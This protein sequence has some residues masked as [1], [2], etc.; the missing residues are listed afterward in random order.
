MCVLD[1]SR[2]VLDRRRFLCVDEP[3]LVRYFES[4]GTY[5]YD[6]NGNHTSD[7]T[8]TEIG[9]RLVEDASYAYQYDDNG[10][11]TR[12]TQKSDANGNVTH[13]YLHG[14]T[15]DQVFADEDALSDVLWS[16]A[17]NLA[18]SATPRRC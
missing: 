7:G 11:R 12:R 5:A 14:L 18:P 1:H 2:T 10:T 6:R 15:C 8:I 4:L 16:L 9:N 3:S 17:D 13:R